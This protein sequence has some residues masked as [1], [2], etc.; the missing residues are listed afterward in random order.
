MYNSIFY[1]LCSPNDKSVPSLSSLLVLPNQSLAY[2]NAYLHL[3][4]ALSHI[5]CISFWSITSFSAN[6]FSKTTLSHN[7]WSYI[8]LK[9]HSMHVIT[10]EHLAYASLPSYTYQDNIPV[11]QDFPLHHFHTSLES[12]SDQELISMHMTLSWVLYRKGPYYQAHTLG[13]T[14]ISN[15][16]KQHT[17]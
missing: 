2:C 14:L 4:T 10:L 12:Y 11:F 9:H 8:D 6:G 7:F 3:S 16:S 17:N 13:L 5:C 1:V 15:I